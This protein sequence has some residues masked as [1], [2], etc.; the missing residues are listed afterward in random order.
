M[1]SILTKR[2][3]NKFTKP[4]NICDTTASHIR[5]YVEI[6]SVSHFSDQLMQGYTIIEYLDLLLAWHLKHIKKDEDIK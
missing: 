1:C 3:L 2:E 5:N 6:A 4:S